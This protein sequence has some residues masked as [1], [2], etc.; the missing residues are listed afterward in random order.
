[1]GGALQ[2]FSV[3]VLAGFL[4]IG[5]E[6]FVPGTVLGVVGGL[7]LL[8]AVIIGFMQ[9]GVEIGA[10]ILIGVLVLL[11]GLLILWMRVFP[12]TRM[13]KALILSQDGKSFKQAA[14]TDLLNQ[15]GVTLSALNPAG[16]AQLNGRRYDVM[17][18]G[19]WID[20]D[21]PVTVTSVDGNRIIVST[22]PAAGPQAGGSP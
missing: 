18:D 3:L 10:L 2:L 22:R 15:A 1:M 5:M 4:L 8:G 14:R 9:F 20:K 17:A 13:G 12:G 6:I 21:T 7:C 16:V 11:A 19:Q